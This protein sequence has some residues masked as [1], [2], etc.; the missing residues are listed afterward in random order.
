MSS[1][2]AASGVFERE[3]GHARSRALVDFAFHFSTASELHLQELD[4]YVRDRK[5]WPS[6]E[7]HGQ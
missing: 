4:R 6:L 7:P 5:P 1:V 2:N 3:L